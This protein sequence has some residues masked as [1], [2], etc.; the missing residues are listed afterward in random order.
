MLTSKKASIIPM[1]FFT[2][3]TASVHKLEPKKKNIRI[4]ISEKDVYLVS[5]TGSLEEKT[6][7]LR[8][9]VEAMTFHKATGDTWVLRP[10][11]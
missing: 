8:A 2:R 6:R 5:D 3:D 4:L 11:N 7:V 9:G 10:L 1:M